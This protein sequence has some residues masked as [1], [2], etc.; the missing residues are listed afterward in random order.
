MTVPPDTVDSCDQCVWI[1]THMPQVKMSS[2]H[3]C[4]VICIGSLWRFPEFSLPDYLLL[5]FWWTC[6]T[7]QPGQLHVECLVLMMCWS[8]GTWLRQMLKM[9]AMSNLPFSSTHASSTTTTTEN[10]C[11]HFHW[12]LLETSHVTGWRELSYFWVWVPFE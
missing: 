1:G 10:R 12:V 8:I 4:A 5:I 11:R 3:H 7:C 2:R 6:Y 9:A